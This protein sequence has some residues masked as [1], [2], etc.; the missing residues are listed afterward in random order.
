MSNCTTAMM[1][2]FWSSIVQHELLDR[3]TWV[4]RDELAS[5]IFD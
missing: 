4:T 3:R 2:S 5:A 1:D